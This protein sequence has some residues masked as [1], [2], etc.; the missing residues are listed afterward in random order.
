M[1]GRLGVDQ[2][3]RA[4][5]LVAA[6][7]E[8][9]T[10]QIVR[11]DAVPQTVLGAGGENLLH[12]FEERRTDE[13]FVTT[14]IG[15]ALIGDDSRVVRVSQHL[16][17]LVQRDW[18]RR[19]VGGRPGSQSLVSH[20]RLEPLEG[21][22]ARGVERPGHLDE[23]CPDFVDFDGVDLSAFVLNTGVSVTEGSTTDGAAA[24]NLLTH[25]VPDVGTVG[26]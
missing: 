4:L 12:P 7:A 16:M 5:A 21:V 25:L 26:L 15:L 22:L 8:Q 2:A 10:F 13:R 19:P 6:V 18:L 14:G 24:L 1:T 23:R 20:R 11:V 3:A 17:Q 9:H